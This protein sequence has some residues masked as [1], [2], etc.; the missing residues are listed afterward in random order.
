MYPAY[1]TS[2]VFFAATTAFR[3]WRGQVIEAERRAAQ[4]VAQAH[5][6]VYELDWRTPIDGGRWGA[7]HTLDIPLT[8]DNVDVAPGMTGD[9]PE[10]RRMAELLMSD[11]WIA[12]ARTGNPNHA[13]LSSWRPYDLTKRYTMSFDLPPRLVEAPQRRE[14]RL[15][16]QVPYTQPGT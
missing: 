11:T 3:S 2:D 14:R 15:I 16:E 6:W 9:G 7:L 4:P 12:F 13:G 10:A 5:T 8:L 1:S